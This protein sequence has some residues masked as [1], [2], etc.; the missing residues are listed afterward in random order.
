MKLDGSLEALAAGGVRNFPVPESYP[1]IVVCDTREQTPFSFDSFGVRVFKTTG[2]LKSGDY[3]ILGFENRI[4]VERKSKADLFSSVSQG[5]ERLEKEFQRLAKME[6][7]ILVCEASQASI[8]DGFA[9][10]QLNPYTVLRTAISWSGRYR[11]PFF[12]CENRTEAEWL[13]LEYL[14]YGWLAFTGQE[15]RKKD[16]TERRASREN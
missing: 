6:R 12:F 1:F 7:A 10:S 15:R 3:S 9:N 13:T 11:V 16:D 14:R 5:R 4:S 8:L 2:T